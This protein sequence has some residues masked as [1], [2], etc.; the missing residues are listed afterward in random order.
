M[1]MKTKEVGGGPA[2]G[3]ADNYVSML[4]QLMNSGG[5][6]TAGSP[7]VG[8]GGD[9]MSVLADILGAGGG[10]AGGA[11]NQLL[12]KQ[13]E[14]D[15]NNIRARFGMSGGTAFG[16]P[17]AHAESL[18]RAEAAPHIAQAIT[19]MQ[20]QAIMPLLQQIGGLSQMGIPQRQVIQQK[21]GLGQAL[22]VVG[23]LAQTGMQFAGGF[24]RGGLPAAPAMDFT[25]ALDGI[26]PNFG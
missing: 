6:G 22:D 24:S 4:Q 20:L 17:A 5:M 8:S 2:T 23:G 11:I 16:T 14:R 21:T 19:G 7:Q 18:Y 9:I 26:T 25:G 3:L 15:V 13:Q 12:S 10:K 1:G